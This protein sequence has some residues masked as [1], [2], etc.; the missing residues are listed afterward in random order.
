MQNNYI[1]ML[2]MYTYASGILYKDSKYVTQIIMKYVKTEK[3][4]ESYIQN[5]DYIYIWQ[6]L[7]CNKIMILIVT[8]KD[9]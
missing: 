2:F 5:K 1:F 8:L 3:L 4:I 9:S 6:R 7:I